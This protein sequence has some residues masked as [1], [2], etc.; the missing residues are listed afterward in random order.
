MFPSGREHAA[1]R[2]ARTTE[3]TMKY[4]GMVSNRRGKD[5]RYGCPVT[6][7]TKDLAPLRDRGI[8]RL[9]TEMTASKLAHT[10]LNQQCSLTDRG[11]HHNSADSEPFLENDDRPRVSLTRVQPCSVCRHDRG[12]LTSQVQALASMVQTIVPYLPQLI[13]SAPPMAFPQMESP[14]ALNRE[15]QLEAEPPQRQVAEAHSASPT[16]ASVRSQSC[17]CD[18]VQTSPNLDTLSSDTADS[19]REQV[20][21]VHQRLDEV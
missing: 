21:Q 2:T 7:T 1:H 11:G 3:A 12:F 17:S 4:D 14:V 13:Q 16:T 20:R 6:I 18:P 19:V 5:L 9:C 8:L 10:G 15:T